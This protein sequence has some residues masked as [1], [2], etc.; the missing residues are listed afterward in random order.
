MDYVI[1]RD[2]KYEVKNNSLDLVNLGIEDITEIQGLDT[3]T[4]LIS[5]D[6]RDNKIKKING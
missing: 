1:Y 3:L 5:L 4:D 6:L 2:K